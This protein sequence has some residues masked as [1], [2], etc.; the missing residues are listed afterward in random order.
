MTEE[1]DF[2]FLTVDHKPASIFLDMGAKKLAPVAS[3]PFQA[4]LRIHMK[5]PREDGL[6]SKAEFDALVAIEDRLKA[7]LVSSQTA[8]VGRCTTDGCRDFYFYVEQPEVWEARAAACMKAAAEYDFEVFTEEDQTWSSYF[9]FLYPGARDQQRMGNR[10]VCSALEEK[11][12]DLTAARDIDHWSYF[13]D[14]DSRARFVRGAGELGFAT[15]ELSTTED[16]EHRFVA[17][18]WRSD[19]PSYQTIDEVTLP[20]FD[21]AIACDGDYDGWE[22]ALVTSSSSR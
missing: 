1:W 8:Y 17:R 10:S 11:G 4:G 13:R 15:R 20:L 22:C 19:V 21:L 12:D 9:E 6:S 18:V 14:A 2:Y 5:A 16:G 7:E 3:L